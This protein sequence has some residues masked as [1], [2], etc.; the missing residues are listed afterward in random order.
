MA[1]SFKIVQCKIF[2]EQNQVLDYDSAV[3][4]LHLDKSNI[5][6][7]VDHELMRL[8]GSEY[9]YKISDL[10]GH[11]E[12]IKYFEQRMVR[13]NIESNNH[14]KEQNL[15][16]E[17]FI[18]DTLTANELI[19]AMAN[20]IHI[21]AATY[22][23]GIDD[24][25]IKTSAYAGIQGERPID[26]WAGAKDFADGQT[27]LDGEVYAST[28]YFSE[29]MKSQ[30]DLRSDYPNDNILSMRNSFPGFSFDEKIENS[31]PRKWD[32]A[33]ID[34]VYQAY[35]TS[36]D[37]NPKCL[38][39]KALWEHIK[40]LAPGSRGEYFTKTLHIRYSRS[41]D[42]VGEN[43][44]S[45]GTTS[46][47]G[48]GY[49]QAHAGG[50]YNV[51]TFN[52]YRYE[53]EELLKKPVLSGPSGTAFRFVNVWHK[54]LIDPQTK[55]LVKVQIPTVQDALLVIMGNLLPPK[56]HH[57]YHEIMDG[58]HGVGGLEYNDK[59]GYSDLQK[60][61]PFILSRPLKKISPTYNSEQFQ[62]TM[63]S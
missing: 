60:I 10:N 8:L 57:T 46:P 49:R 53:A 17:T 9:P 38:S 32:Q 25:A 2:D 6:K 42:R 22:V 55:F 36:P 54:I 1:S 21:I 37:V 45:L 16:Y 4:S 52:P 27:T 7:L 62:G 61:C 35:L 51:I 19:I 47:Q 28:Q 39:Q 18:G 30:S 59:S 26:T 14:T 24:K 34:I 41:T 12:H 33:T 29:L 50:Q 44:S 23:K 5:S 40:S 20:R 58:V 3:R 11:F 15:A 56:G 43:P 31:E 48:A 13:G 63:R